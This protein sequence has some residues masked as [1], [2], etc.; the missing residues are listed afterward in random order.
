[1]RRLFLTVL[2]LGLALA[3]PALAASRV[4]DVA[5]LQSSRDNQLVGYGLVVGLAGSGDSLRNA[6]FTEQSMRS[7]LDNLGVATAQGR[8]R[9]DNIAA[10]IVTAN[11]P[12][13]VRHGARIDVTV[14][15]LGDAT[16]L[17][18]GQLVMTPLRGAD[19]EIYAVA[20]GP[21]SISGFQAQGAAET[22]S[23]G[24][25]TAGRI[26]G[27]AIVEREVQADFK[28]E[29]LMTMQL[30]NPDFSTAVAI[31]DTINQHASQEYGVRPATEVDARTIMIKKP[32]GVSTAR[33]VASI[34]NLMVETDAPA[35]VV[36]DE[37][38]GTVVI[39][40]D[41]RISKVAVSHGTLTVRV[42]EQP[43]VVQPLP[44]SDG[45]TAVEPNTIVDVA[46]AGTQLA[47]V[48]GSNLQSLVEGLNRLGVG[49][50]DIISILQAV[51]SAGAI[52]A[53]IVVQ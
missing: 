47:T 45:Q 18:G 11:L 27:G 29:H 2:A 20:Q 17:R 51:K 42:T 53:E 21:V 32:D 40:Q 7:M 25:P 39:G 6:P 52:Q 30:R 9:L 37:S 3:G 48:D 44:F 16:S 10:V 4:K 34:E 14:S 46:E 35:R 8:A 43:Q 15:S 1:M 13:F 50:S 5:V 26:A 31:T 19:G 38:S 23:Q 24:T 12:P 33:F 41:V 28:D 49:P 36:L 22:V